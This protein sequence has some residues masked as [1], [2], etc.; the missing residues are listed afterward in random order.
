MVVVTLD[1]SGLSKEIGNDLI[2]K[3]YKVEYVSILDKADDN[4]C[5]YNLD[6]VSDS[7]VKALYEAITKDNEALIGYIHVAS[8]NGENIEINKIFGEKEIDA[9]KANFLIAKYFSSFSKKQNDGKGF[10][11]AVT[12]MDGN[13]GLSGDNTAAVLQGGFYGLVKSLAR[14]W[15]NTKCSVIDIPVDCDNSKASAYV[16]EE[17][18]S[19][20]EGIVEVGRTSDGERFTI[21]MIE[22]YDADPANRLPGKDDVFL[23]TGGGRGVSAVCAINLAKEYKCKFIL[24]GRSSIDNDFSWTNGETDQTKLRQLIIAQLRETGKVIKPAEVDKMI[25]SIKNQDEIKKNLDAIILAGG[26][27]VY[28]P[29]DVTNEK[30]LKEVILKGENEMGMVTGFA[31]G[32]GVIADKKIEKKTEKD[33]NN[34]F[35]TK[36]IGLNKVM[37]ILNPEQLKYVIMFSSVAAYFGNEGQT[38]YSMANEVLNKFAYAYRKKFPDTFVLSI[39]WG[40][41]KGGMV[42]EALQYVI[43]A[44]GEK[45]I[46]LNVGADYFA[47]QL[48]Y[49]FKPETCQLCIAGTD[50]YIPH[51]IDFTEI[52]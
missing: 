6:S 50:L 39:N 40:P 46:P 1:K 19:E 4:N 48:H 23:I 3:G 36:I 8:S 14:E 27:V 18:F 9:L 11:A 15:K 21:S 5:K 43:T 16:L 37:N 51:D 2:K 17:I 28:Y 41:W 44:I 33:F 31:H 35:G 25:S 12:R 26:K 49:S 30:E 52:M 20:S 13:M 34:V 47:E 7:K 38:D 32:V 24:L 22:R 10:F 29:C 42:S 45:M